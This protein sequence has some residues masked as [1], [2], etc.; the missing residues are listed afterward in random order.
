MNTFMFGFIYPA[1]L[2]YIHFCVVSTYIINA[3]K[4]L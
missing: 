4:V 1:L 3:C 2:K